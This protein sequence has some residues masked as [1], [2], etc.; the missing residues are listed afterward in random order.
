M[1]HKK[2]KAKNILLI[3]ALVFCISGACP[4]VSFA[5]GVDLPAGGV[6]A[7][8]IPGAAGGFSTAKNFH[9]FSN[10]AEVHVHTNGNIATGNLIGDV[11]FGTNVH[12]GGVLKDIHYLRSVTQIASSSF[13]AST[14]SRGLKVVFGAGVNLSWVD[15][16]N[17]LAVNGTELGNVKKSGEAFIDKNGQ[18]YIDFTTVFNELR[19][20]SDAFASNTQTTGVAI[21]FGDQNNRVIDVSNANVLATGAVKLTK[22]NE[23]GT[24]TLSGATFDLYRTGTQNPIEMGLETNENGEITVIGLAAGDYFFR[25]TQAPA[26]YEAIQQE[27]SFQIASANTSS[28]GYIYVTLTKAQL[29]QS[30]PIKITGLSKNRPGVIVNVDMQGSNS[31]HINS[32][33]T[34]VIDGVQRNNKETEDFSDAK[35]LW[36]FPNSTQN[37]YVDRPFLG[38][39]LATGAYVVANQNLDGSIIADRVNINGGESHRW[40][41]QMQADT[42]AEP[43]EVEVRNR[44]KP[45]GVTF[46]KV[47][48]G[49]GA[50]LAGAEIT[51]SGTDVNGGA[52]SETWTSEGTAKVLQLPAGEYTMAEDQAPLGYAVAA[53]ITFRVE[54]DG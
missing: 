36:N 47:A 15:N 38:T 40:D 4:V 39:I 37:I 35:L 18:T 6:V 30:T 14:L 49:Q 46:S 13:V 12:S 29:E 53:S 9:I 2:S 27:T 21:N 26:G 10:E 42:S 25:E 5:A 19:V 16:G 33:I 22:R 24:K 23:N 41:F 45:Y 54:A 8:D 20:D 17:K 3:L 43:V 32:Q 34:L 28:S 11:N 48:A 52:F 31:L 1:M 7:D 44:L 51:V 50:E